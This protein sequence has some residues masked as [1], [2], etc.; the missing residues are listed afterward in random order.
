VRAAGSRADLREGCMNESIFGGQGENRLY[1]DLAWRFPF[2]SPLESYLDETEL[3]CRR[4]TGLLRIPGITLLHLGCGAGLNDFV[5]KRHFRITGL[6]ASETVLGRARSLNPEARYLRGDFRSA[7]LGEVFSVVAA[8]DCLDYMLTEV[9]LRAAFA[10]AW[11]HL[12]PGGV[13]FFLLAASRETFQQNRTTCWTNSAGGTDVVFIEN[14]YDPDPGDTRNETT[15]LY[16]LR[17]GGKL[18]VEHDRHNFGLFAA[19]RVRELL[20]EV[21]FEV[22]FEDYHPTPGAFGLPEQG[23]EASFPM[24]FGLK[25]A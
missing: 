7:R 12:A 2:I 8:V 17:Q 25:R 1:G 21:G 19:A 22:R 3:F 6:D 13:F 24:F 20:T 16:L 9:D 4:I 5:F 14:I 15:M 18:R 10:T 11:E 23:G